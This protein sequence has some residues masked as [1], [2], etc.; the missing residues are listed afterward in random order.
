MRQDAFFNKRNW[1]FSYNVERLGNTP[2]SR[3]NNASEACFGWMKKIYSELNNKKTFI[4]ALFC[5]LRFVILTKESIMR[6]NLQ[7]LS[8][9]ADGLHQLLEYRRFYNTP[10][11]K[12]L[13]I[14]DDIPHISTEKFKCSTAVVVV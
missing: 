13:T 9:E 10:L 1:A 14:F 12:F 7:T 4:D 2:L 6:N 8:Y 5:V 3:T 11:L